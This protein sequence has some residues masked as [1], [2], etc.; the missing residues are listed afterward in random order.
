M[1]LSIKANIEMVR[2]KIEQ[3]ARE[4]SGPLK[5]KLIA[6][7]KLQPVASIEAAL[8]AGQR[9]FGENRVQ[10]AR[11]K[12]PALRARYPE[13]ELHLIG[14]LQ[15]NKA[16]DAVALFDVIQTVDRE[17][18]ATVLAREMQQ[19]GRWPRLF[20]QV[21]VGEELQKAGVVP[22]D[23]ADFLQFCRR[24]LALQIDG[25]MAIPPIDEEPSPYF[26]MLRELAKANEIKQL[27][28]GMSADFETA[29]AFEADYVRVGTAV[30]GARDQR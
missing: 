5:T 3:A 15:S 26:M 13:I 20:V 29:A 17:K 4:A 8:E 2:A 22:R 27:S 18:I 19:Q 23:L 24:D 28:M 12:F 30:F 10:E 7:S 21:N 9:I 14:P 16:R 25:L 11:A 6:V 1:S